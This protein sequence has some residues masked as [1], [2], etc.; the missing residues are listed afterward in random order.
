MARAKKA[1]AE[2][3][4]EAPCCNARGGILPLTNFGTVAFTSAQADG[5]AL[6][7]SHPARINMVAA[8]GTTKAKTSSLANGDDFSVTR[9]HS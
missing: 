7:N 4:A 3:I 9:T 8:N 2:V 6:G 5:V 1:S